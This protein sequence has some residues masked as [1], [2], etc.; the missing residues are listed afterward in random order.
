MS[1]TGHVNKYIMVH[2]S[3]YMVAST[4]SAGEFIEDGRSEVWRMDNKNAHL[5]RVYDYDDG[6]FKYPLTNK[7]LRI[8]AFNTQFKRKKMTVFETRDEYNDAMFLT[9]L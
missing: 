1:K 2:L 9:L 4:P 7:T 6:K 8:A 5:Y 3:Y